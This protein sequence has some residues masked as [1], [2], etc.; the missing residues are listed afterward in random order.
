MWVEPAPEMLVEPTPEEDAAEHFRAKLVATA[1]AGSHSPS[2]DT[3]IHLIK[4][5]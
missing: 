3:F 1:A 4:H 5:E 2:L